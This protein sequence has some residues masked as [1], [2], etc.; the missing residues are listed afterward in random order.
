MDSTL[1]NNDGI[2]PLVAGNLV[3][4]LAAT[5]ADIDAAQALRYRVF[6]EEMDAIPSAENIRSRRDVDAFDRLCDHLLVIASVLAVD[7]VA[8]SGEPLIRFH[9]RYPQLAG[10]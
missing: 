3:A 1:L 2:A 6:F 8:R 5:E 9:R 7:S 10:H 4:R